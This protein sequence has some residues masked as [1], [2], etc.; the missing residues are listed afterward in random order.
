MRVSCF[1]TVILN[2]VDE[3]AS[4]HIHVTDKGFVFVNFSA[5]EPV[6]FEEHFGS[7]PKEWAKL[8][9]EEYQYCSEVSWT[10]TGK[11]NWKSRYSI[12]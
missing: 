1:E 7:L 11:Y 9:V 12:P 3:V 2:E 10:V 6:P 5:D 4:S 8:S